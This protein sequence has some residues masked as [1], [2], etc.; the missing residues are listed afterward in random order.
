MQNNFDIIIVGGGPTGIVLAN[1]LGQSGVKVGVIEKQKEVFPIPRATHVDEETL[2]NFQMTGLMAELELHTSLFGVVDIVDEN[3]KVIFTE[4]VIQKESEMAYLGSRF[5]DQPAFERILRKGIDRFDTVTLF[6][7]VE[8]QRIEQTAQEIIITASD[9]TTNE[10]SIYTAKYLVG[11]DGGRSTVRTALNID[12][13][14]L[15]PARDWVIVDT[16][17]KKSC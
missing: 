6:A 17:L 12:M 8:V 15:E 10:V 2:R 1:L 14:A 9:V 13:K 16:L 4:E 11:A 3:G 7:G 5:F